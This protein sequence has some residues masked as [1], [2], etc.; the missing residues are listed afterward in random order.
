MGGTAMR[1]RAAVA[2]GWRGGC[3]P[4]PVARACGDGRQGGSGERETQ[5][6]YAAMDQAQEYID[7]NAYDPMVT[8]RIANALFPLGMEGAL[9]AM[10][11]TL[12]A[13]ERGS[14]ERQGL[15]L[16]LRALFDVP[17]PPG[18]MPPMGIGGTSPEPRDPRQAPRFPLMLVDDV[19]LL[20][21]G[22]Y[23]LGGKPEPVSA[24]VAYFR[25]H[26]VF[27]SAP[28]KPAP[29][30]LDL[31]PKLETAAKLGFGPP[32]G[33]HA[34]GQASLAKGVRALLWAQLQRVEDEMY[35]TRRRATIRPNNCWHG[36][37]SAGAKR[38]A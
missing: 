16:A 30:P 11:V 34:G 12:R 22:G 3:S 31:L 7:G 18:Y 1:Q 9:D 17:N 38:T 26:G 21:V 36:Q 33:I 5:R 2:I 6:L 10:S 8:V 35:R 24:H 20:V 19:P 14:R 13:R 27:R 4:G 23:T 15:F 25:K 32:V 29:R 28:L 37:S